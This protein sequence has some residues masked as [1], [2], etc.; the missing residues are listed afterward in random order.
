MLEKGIPVPEKVV[1]LYNGTEIIATATT[2]QCGLVFFNVSWSEGRTPGV[3]VFHELIYNV[4]EELTILVDGVE[5]DIGV[6]SD[7]PIV[8][9]LNESKLPLIYAYTIITVLVL[10]VALILSRKRF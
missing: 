1:E 7:T 5:L 4:G 8:I 3:Y 10:Y 9:E 2:D 6:L